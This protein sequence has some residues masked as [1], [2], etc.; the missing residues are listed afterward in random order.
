M[1]YLPL[2]L[3][4]N[5]LKLKEAAQNKSDSLFIWLSVSWFNIY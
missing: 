3:Q 4:V 1:V 2:Q 5:K